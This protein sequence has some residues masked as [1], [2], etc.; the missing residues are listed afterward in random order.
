MIN[1]T[2]GTLALVTNNVPALGFL[3]Q[4]PIE[5]FE[6]PDY[7]NTSFSLPGRHGASFSSQFYDTRLINLQGIIMATNPTDFE[8]YRQQ[9]SLATALKR[10]ANGY[11]I[12]TRISFTTMANKSYYIDVYFDKPI[13]PYEKPNMSSFM[14][15]ATAADPF[16]YGATQVVSGN[17]SPPTGGGYVVPMIVPYA[18]SGST[19]GVVTL[20]NAGVE[21]VKPLIYL[22]GSLTSPLITNQTTG[23]SLQLSYTLAAINNA[24]IDMANQTIKLNNSSSLIG[25]KT[26]TSD[27]WALQPGNNNISISTNSSS[28]TG[29]AVIKFNPPYVGV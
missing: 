18:S 4:T 24:T 10:D 25:S 16:I 23:K 7:R 5:G 19:G 22:Y 28:D 14:L 12:P 13:F 27:W 26:I 8:T 21:D 2:I 15:T 9:L 1:F 6:A 20:N 29:Y 3:L 17:I 11:P